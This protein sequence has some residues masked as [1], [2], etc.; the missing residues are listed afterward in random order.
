M[1]EIQISMSH[2]DRIIFASNR[3]ANPPGLATR[4]DPVP[5][6][7]RTGKLP[8]HCARSPSKDYRCGHE[9]KID[10]RSTDRA[11]ALPI[12]AAIGSQ[13]PSS[14]RCGRS[15][16]RHSTRNRDHGR[17]GTATTRA[18]AA[19]LTPVSTITRRPHLSTI[20]IRPGTATGEDGEFSAASKRS[21]NNG[22]LPVEGSQLI[23]AGANLVT[24]SASTSRPLGPAVAT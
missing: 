4:T 6:A 21:G 3:K 2:R 20:S 14:C 9:S 8:G 1:A 12:P 13:S 22:G 24:S 5:I 18:S 11:A 16:A 10:D 7:S 23:I 19:A 15:L 17:S